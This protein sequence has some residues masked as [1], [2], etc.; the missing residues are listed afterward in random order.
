MSMTKEDLLELFRQTNAM[1]QETSL[2][3]S[4]TDRLIK[5]TALRQQET[6]RQM[7]ETALRQQETNRQMKEELVLRQQESDRQMQES[8]RRQRETDRLIKEMNRSLGRLGNRLGEFVEEM[9][10]PAVVKL[11]QQRGIDVHHVFKRA[12][13]QLDGE[14]MEV[15][16]LLVNSGD[17]ILVE[18]KSELSVDDVK[19]HL[20]R[21]ARFKR[22]FPMYENHRIMGAVA[23]MVVPDES[24]R[25]AYR[26]GLFV[27]AQSGEA[28]LIRN[29]EKF[30]PAYW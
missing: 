7:K 26:Q 8:E 6:D 24:A 4:E 16:L 22:L 10:R 25:F 28:M 17:A 15:D 29:D 12:S 13:A 1:L 2:R 14:E 9:G 11:F 3:Q 20:Q 27:L 23:G 5:E 30:K 19:E 21:L 18:T